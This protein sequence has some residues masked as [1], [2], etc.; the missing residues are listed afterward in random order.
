[1]NEPLNQNKRGGCYQSLEDQRR[2]T[3]RHSHLSVA[4][5]VQ[6]LQHRPVHRQHGKRRHQEGPPSRLVERSD[7]GELSTPPPSRS[8]DPSD[9]PPS[10]AELLEEPPVQHDQRHSRADVAPLHDHR[11]HLTLL[12]PRRLQ[13]SRRP[14]PQPPTVPPRSL[15]NSDFLT[16][17]SPS[18]P[19]SWF[20][21]AP[22][23]CWGSPSTGSWR[24]RPCLPTGRST[25]P[26]R[27]SAPAGSR[28]S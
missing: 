10:T 26:T 14:A 27:G 19:W 11:E 3:F 18:G 16:S 6:Q 17:C 20:T 8:C 24:R 22:A 25:S 9:C 1:M 4:F 5:P 7:R 13:V 23:R 12:Q 15:P 28:V 2:I 21:S